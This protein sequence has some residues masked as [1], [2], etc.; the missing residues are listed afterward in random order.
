MDKLH[1]KLRVTSYELQVG[2]K[3]KAEGRK[4]KIF[5]LDLIFSYLFAHSLAHLFS[6]YNRKFAIVNHNSLCA[7]VVKRSTYSFIFNFQLNKKYYKN[8]Y[9]WKQY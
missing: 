4:Q 6:I 1:N 5:I 2:K 9:I 3:Q 7:F 8:L